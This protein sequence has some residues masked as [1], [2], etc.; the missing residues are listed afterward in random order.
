M[1]VFRRLVYAALCAGLISGIVA[2]AAH[3][4]GTVPLILK[5]ETYEQTAQHPPAETHSH[6]SVTAAEWVRATP[7]TW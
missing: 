4:L 2:A 5:A 1:G 7:S 3:Q 6:A